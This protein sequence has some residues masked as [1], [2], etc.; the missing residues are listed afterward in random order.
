MSSACPSVLTLATIKF[1]VDLT[2]INFCLDN[3][4][5]FPSFPKLQKFMNLHISYAFWLGFVVIFV[6]SWPFKTQVLSAYMYGL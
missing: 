4:V 1:Y 2:K 5:F 6:I 3:S